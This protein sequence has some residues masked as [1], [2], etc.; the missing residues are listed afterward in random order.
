MENHQHRHFGSVSYEMSACPTFTNPWTNTQGPATNSM[1]TTSQQMPSLGYDQVSKQQTARAHNGTIQY[2]AI[3]ATAAALNSAPSNAFSNASYG[4]P[5][6]IPTSQDF[7][8]ANRAGPPSNYPGSE[9]SFSTAP[10]PTTHSYPASTTS[11]DS[12]PYPTSQT[13]NTYG[14]QPQ[15]PTVADRRLSG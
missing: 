10:S 9:H 3:P 11:Y 2:S 6:S 14:L 7:L 8:G 13:R 4:P 1:Y 5:D 15:Q 12:M